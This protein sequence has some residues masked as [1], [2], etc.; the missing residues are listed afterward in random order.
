[1]GGIGGERALARDSVAEAREQLVDGMHDDGDFAGCGR[2]VQWRQIARLAR[3][4][5]GGG[6]AQRCEPALDDDSDDTQHQQ[7]GENHRRYPLAQH[8]PADFGADAVALADRDPDVLVVE[9]EHPPPVAVRT[10]IGITALQARTPGL[11]GRRGRAQQQAAVAP[12]LKR[13]V[14]LVGMPP[15]L[16]LFTVVANAPARRC[17]C[18]EVGDQ[19]LGGVGGIV[20]GLPQQARVLGELGIE[21]LGDLVLD[22]VVTPGHARGQQCRDRQRQRQGEEAADRD[23][24]GSTT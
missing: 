15:D 14:A 6:G 1:M 5:R 4:Q 24:G 17:Q 20:G 19:R 3:A 12:D 2:D 13:D 7:D 10:D 23:H 22:G 9:G 11:R 21:N 8:L 16:G 18:K